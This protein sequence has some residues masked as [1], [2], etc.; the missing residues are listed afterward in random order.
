[1]VSISSTL[2]LSGFSTFL[3]HRDVVVANLNGRVPD[4]GTIVEATL[5]CHS[6]KPLVLYKTDVRSM[7]GGSDNPMVTG[8][9]D[10]ESIND[11]SALPAAVERAVAIHSSENYPKPWNLA[12]P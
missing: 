2:E 4:E 3:P 8:L 9:G 5:A 10:F 6:G 12:H 7:L 11:S 1:M